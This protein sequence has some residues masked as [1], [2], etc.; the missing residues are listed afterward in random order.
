V[1]VLVTILQAIYDEEIAGGILVTDVPGSKK[2]V[3]KGLGGS[4]RVVPVT[5][6]YIRP[7]S[8]DFARLASLNWSARRWVGYLEVNART[9]PPARVQ[10][11][12]NT[13]FLGFQTGEKS[14]LSHPVYLNQLDAR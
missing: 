14:R 13:V 12:P 3:P 11:L 1:T 2:A 10:E 5:E 8:Y 7:T 9:R 6:H 4:F